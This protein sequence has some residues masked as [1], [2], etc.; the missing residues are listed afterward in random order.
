MLPTDISGSTATIRHSEIQTMGVRM[1]VGD[2][3][4]RLLNVGVPG[5]ALVNNVKVRIVAALPNGKECAYFVSS[6]ASLVEVQSPIKICGDIHGQFADVLR[7]FDRGGFSPVVNYLFLGDYVLTAAIKILNVL[8]YSSATRSNN[9]LWNKFYGLSVKYPGNFFI[10]EETMN[11]HR[12]IECTASSKNA[13]GATIALDC[14]SVFKF[15]NSLLFRISFILFD[16]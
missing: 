3:V 8:R 1:G 13:T 12:L 10:C 14:G 4:V 16:P 6:Q 15:L 7:L 11:A 5:C 2:M 9:A